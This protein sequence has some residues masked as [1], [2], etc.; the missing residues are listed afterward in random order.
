MKNPNA[1]IYIG[2]QPFEVVEVIDEFHPDEYVLA[3]LN[4]DDVQ[5]AQRAINY[6]H[7]VGWKIAYHVIPGKVTQNDPLA[8]RWGYAEGIALMDEVLA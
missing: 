7:S 6:Q 5:G 8:M 1:I 4:K 2:N 3:R